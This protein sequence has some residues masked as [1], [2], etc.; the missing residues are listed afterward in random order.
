M[1]LRLSVVIPTCD[2]PETVGACLKTICQQD[3][4]NLQIVVQDNASDNRTTEIISSI[5][6]RRIIH[7]RSTKRQSMR[8]NFESGLD[9]VD[10]DY[11]IYLGDD[12]GL[13]PYTLSYLANLLKDRQPDFVSA[14]A[15][16]YAWPSFALDRRGFMNV[17]KAKLWG[18][19]VE[20]D[21]AAFKQSLLDGRKLETGPFGQIYLGCVSRRL[22]DRIRTKT[23]GVYFAH[24]Q[25]DT[26]TSIAN[27]FAAKSA[28]LVH[29]P[30][31]IAGKS[32][33][34][35]G[36]AFALED[37]SRPE[38]ARRFEADNERDDGKLSDA[39][40]AIPSTTYF[41][42]KCLLAAKSLLGDE[43]V[44]NTDKWVRKV[45]QEISANGESARSGLMSLKT[46]PDFAKLKLELASGDVTRISSK[47]NRFKGI[48]MAGI[49]CRTGGKN[50]DDVYSASRLLDQIAGAPDCDG[51]RPVWWQVF[52]KEI[53]WIK[54]MG[55]C[56]AAN[57]NA[58]RHWATLQ[59]KSTS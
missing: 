29:H 52:M 46:D 10:G 53:R 15:A 7:Q 45:L 8:A 13:A 43:G 42:Y 14:T 44:V 23:K 12:D 9:V 18:G 30:L 34:S 22:I 2:R 17:R 49:G 6:D 54:V 50:E 57:H 11:V 25:P 27:I 40:A 35:N 55:I 26:Y 58:N 3:Y 16:K 36:A 4:G 19:C 37:N 39:N 20:A 32:A 1:S 33:A 56:M 41:I 21:C 48:R 38:I 24:T 31:F 5:D 59:A 28:L 51:L 47:R